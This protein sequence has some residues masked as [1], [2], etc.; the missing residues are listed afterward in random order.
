MT[1][2]LS[3]T[4]VDALLAPD[5]AL[6]AM[7]RCYRHL[8]E[9]AAEQ[10]RPAQLALDGGRLRVDAAA[11]L[12][13]GLAAVRA[14]TSFGAGSSAAIAVFAAGQPELVAILA[15][16]TLTRRRAGA[17]SGLAARVLAPAGARSVGVIGCGNQA[18]GQVE[19]IR[20][21]LPAIERVVVH[22][23]DEE[24]RAAFAAEVAGEAADHGRE[25]AE[26]DVVVTATSSRDPV[27][28]GDWLRPGTLVIAVGATSPGAR[29]LDNAV[30]GRATFVC[31]D[32]VEQARLRASDLVDT[33]EQGLLDWLEV[34]ELAAVVTG[35]VPARQGEG[36]IV[37]F[38]SVGT[39]ADD[40]AAVAAVLALASG[41]AVGV[42][43]PGPAGG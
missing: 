6:E 20:A 26:Q 11:D 5:A 7:E 34:H 36:D 13:V 37:L 17:T 30:V 4:D 28:R 31:C 10:L 43:L 24:R 23:R 32:S 29:E 9:G 35:E 21:A 19:G 14:S 8:A 27:L 42:D 40:L 25:A 3:D 2:Y 15:A 18:R 33:V 41:R 38:K 12:E 22:C 39:A 1:L 16:S